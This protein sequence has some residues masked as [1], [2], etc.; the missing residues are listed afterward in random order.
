MQ[1]PVSFDDAFTLL[2]S[3]LP[4]TVA[5]PGRGEWVAVANADGR[6]LVEPAY[7]AIDVPPFDRAMMD[8]YAL[9]AADLAERRT[10]LRS[11]LAVA[12]GHTPRV[13]MEPGMCARVLTGAPVPMGTAAVVRQEWCTESDGEI[14]VLRWPAPGES[15]QPAGQDGRSGEPLLPAG[16]VLSALDCAVLQTFGVKQVRV[17]RRLRAALLVTGDELAPAGGPLAPG[18]IYG[19]NDRM[20]DGCLRADGLEVV[21]TAHLRDDPRELATAITRAAADADVIV[22]TGGVSVGDFDFT[23]HAV[24][25]VLGPL[26]LRKVL[27]RPGSPL[28]FAVRDQVAC[29]GLSGNPAACFAQYETLIGPALRCSLGQTD[30]PFPATGILAHDVQLKP[31]KH[32]VVHRGKMHLQAGQL[33]VDCRMAQS[34]GVVSSLLAS[35]VLVRLDD[36]DYRAGDI[37]PIR[38]LQWPSA[39]S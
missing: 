35:D 30:V 18:Q 2:K 25:Q 7:A 12:A 36:A 13:A 38:G 32:T 8:G 28:V 19:T 14:E 37:V 3:H 29:F 6:T 4:F 20:L 23:P 15:I 11:V 9:T 21:Q 17:A 31:V 10:P 24:E 1:S 16:R 39:A 34:T 26:L 22:V 5:D 33:L 27:M